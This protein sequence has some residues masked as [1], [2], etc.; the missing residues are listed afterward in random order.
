VNKTKVIITVILV[1]LIVLSGCLTPTATMDS[2]QDLGRP[3]FNNSHAI[4]IEKTIR[5]IPIQDL[6]T[7]NINNGE[8]VI[9]ASMERV[10]NDDTGLVPLIEDNLIYNLTE[11]GYPVLEREDEI[12]FQLD[13]ERGN[14]YTAFAERELPVDPVLRLIYE[15]DKN[16][17]N[18][19]DF[20]SVL[21][22]AN[23]GLVV[24]GNE[25]QAA[26]NTIDPA[27]YGEILQFYKTLDA[28]F[29]EK[30]NLAVSNVELKTAD[31]LVS[32]R[33]L[34]C[35]ILIDLEQKEVEQ[36]EKSS[37]LT[38]EKKKLW[39]H[40]YNREANTRLFVRVVDAKTGEI[41]GAKI[42][43]NINSDTIEFWQGDEETSGDYFRRMTAYEKL[44]KN[45]HYTYY[46][47]QLPLQRGT[48]S[49]QVYVKNEKVDG[50]AAPA[51][52]SFFGGEEETDSLSLS[53]DGGSEVMS[54]DDIWSIIGI[55]GGVSLGAILLGVALSGL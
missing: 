21:T 31:V 4:L 51:A 42:I 25:T 52:P 53:P 18:Y 23:T 27:V 39:R 19:L 38:D 33:V 41:R 45:Y 24:N 20:A 12:L 26:L 48:S 13:K 34:E 2:Q 28:S 16:G 32:Y 5:E 49:Q 22:A 15:M 3:T 10:Y 1:M 17:L 54:D 47:Q 50:E 6:I 30:R 55:V 40:K 29:F 8:K 7:D 46:D 36:G 9:V 35:G 11:L 37:S 14:I 43:E 44:L